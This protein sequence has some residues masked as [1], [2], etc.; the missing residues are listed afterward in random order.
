MTKTKK[1]LITILIIILIPVGYYL[2]SPIF[3]NIKVDEAMPVSTEQATTTDIEIRRAEIVDT[4]IHPAKGF[5]RIIKDANDTYIRYEDFKTINGP[6]IYVYL[7]NDI[8]A[9]DF[10]SLGKVKATEGN[11]NYKVPEGVNVKD[12]KYVIIWC[13]AFNVLFNY[14]DISGL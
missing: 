10:V 1:T 13:E 4:A 14:A 3:I 5:V 12:Y 11:V 6:D 9:K 8:E 7:S 2:I